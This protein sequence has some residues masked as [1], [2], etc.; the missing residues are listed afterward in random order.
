MEVSD[1]DADKMNDDE[2]EARPKKTKEVMPKYLSFNKGVMDSDDLLPLNANSETL[3][4]SKIIRDI[5]KNLVRKDIE[6]PR[7]LGGEG[8]IQE[9]EGRQNWQ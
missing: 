3:Q 5:S 8:R 4:D 9:G 2:E 7:K 1:K 6:M